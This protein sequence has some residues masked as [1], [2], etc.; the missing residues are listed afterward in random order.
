METNQNCDTFHKT[1]VDHKKNI[2]LT[3]CRFRT[4]NAVSIEQDWR[5]NNDYYR[6]VLTF[7][8][9]STCI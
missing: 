7:F 8:K 5:Y 9:K 4:H 6:K 1:D 3:V 2:L